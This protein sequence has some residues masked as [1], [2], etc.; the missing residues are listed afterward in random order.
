[1]S[2]AISHVPAARRSFEAQANPHAIEPRMVLRDVAA[3][4][5]RLGVPTPR[6]AAIAP[7]FADAP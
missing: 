5:H 4:A 2:L 7:L 1:M 6:I 3:D